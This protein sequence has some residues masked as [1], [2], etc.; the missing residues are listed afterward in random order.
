M[1]A[2]VAKLVT[3]RGYQARPQKYLVKLI[4]LMGLVALLD[5]YI[6]MIKTTAIPFAIKEYGLTASEFS[7]YEALYLASTFLIF[8]L[9]GLTDI[10]GRKFSILV[11]TL[12]M[13]LSSL[14]IV[15]FT[16]RFHL[17][18]IFYTLAMFTTVSNMWSIPI[19]EESPADKRAKYV[20]I[21]YVIGLIPL[22]AILPP[23]LENMLGLSWKWMY[24]VAF[25][26]MLPVLVI[27]L[28]MKETKRYE[29]IV[30]E[31]RS[32]ERKRHFYG[33]GV[34]NKQD[35][36]YIAIASSIWLC[37]LVYSML[38]FWAGYYFMTVNGYTLNQWSLTLLATLIMAIIGG[39]T[40]GAI[41]DKVGRKPAFVVGCIS[42][43]LVLLVLGFAE[44]W[45]L[46]VAA[47]ITGYFT[48]FT[49][50]WIVVYIPEVFPTE[51]RGACMGWTTTIA[52]VSYVVGPALAAILLKAS[53]TMEWFWV[54][55]AAIVLIPIGIILTVNP[56]ET[57]TKELEEIEVKR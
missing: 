36:R 16:P 33:L 55:A 20:S 31:R 7:W 45:L 30:A 50:T 40:S 42:L 46:P 19:S 21:V 22:Q 44:G 57:K 17:F 4:I 27:W 49:Y 3:E 10:I 54:A 6:S 14:A 32:G 9:N 38:Y 12:M 43:C 35:W 56:Y 18:M 29:T 24:G 51:R 5:Q 53:P 8:L 34:I 2:T 47:I 15:F 26:M 48:S 25:L 28:S 52:R 1:N 41:M 37:W 11:L 13:G 39:L 23:I